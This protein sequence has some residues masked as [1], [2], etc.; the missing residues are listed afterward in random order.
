MVGKEVTERDGIIIERSFNKEGEEISVKIQLK[1]SDLEVT[2]LPESCCCCPVGFMD[3]SCGRR[4]PLDH[5]FR[6]PNCKLKLVNPFKYVTV[7]GNDKLSSYIGLH[8]H[9]MNEMRILHDN[10]VSNV[11]TVKNYKSKLRELNK[12]IEEIELKLEELEEN[13]G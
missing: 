3:H 12:A 11:Y 1:Y 5:K 10:F 9:L 8:N 2:K 13:D 6:S 7:I 4:V